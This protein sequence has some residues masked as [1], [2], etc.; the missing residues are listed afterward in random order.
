[1]TAGSQRFLMQRYGVGSP[2]GTVTPDFPGQ[3]YEDQTPGPPWW[4]NGAT[5]ADWG[6]TYEIDEVCR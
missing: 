6:C 2:L 3:V 4:A 1:M 5:S